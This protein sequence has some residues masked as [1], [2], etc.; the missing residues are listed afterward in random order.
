MIVI[1]MLDVDVRD[2]RTRIWIW[3]EGGGCRDVRMACDGMMF[4]LEL[5]GVRCLD[6]DAVRCWMRVH[7]QPRS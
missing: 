1:I 2:R 5:F 7:D 6:L 3:I 4:D